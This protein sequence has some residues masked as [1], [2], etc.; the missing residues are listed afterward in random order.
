MTFL[1]RIFPAR[2]MPRRAVHVVVESITN[3][4]GMAVF[5][6]PGVFVIDDMVVLP[7]GTHVAAMAT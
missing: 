7:V 3:V 1:G 6:P 4:I 5:V 2:G